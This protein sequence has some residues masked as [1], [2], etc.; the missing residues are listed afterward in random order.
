MYFASA[1]ECLVASSICREPGRQWK[2]QLP[3]IPLPTDIVTFVHSNSTL[4]DFCYFSPVLLL[5]LRACSCRKELGIG[6]ASYKPGLNFQLCFCLARGR[7]NI[8]NPLTSNLLVL[9]H[10]CSFL[11]LWTFPLYVNLLTGETALLNIYMYAV[12]EMSSPPSSLS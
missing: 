7:P 5:A 1:W 8:L 3:N 4:E 11:K 2:M 9:V 6:V 10:E 12:F